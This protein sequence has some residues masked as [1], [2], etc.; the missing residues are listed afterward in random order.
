MRIQK[1]FR[2]VEIQ[3]GTGE[4]GTPKSLSSEQWENWPLGWTPD[5]QSVILLSNRQGKSA[6]YQQNLTTQEM[7]P[8]V[9]DEGAGNAVVSPDGQWVLFTRPSGQIVPANQ[10]N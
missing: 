10:R 5:S 6:I 4:I 2:M 9:S 3:G 8:L 1:V 7:H